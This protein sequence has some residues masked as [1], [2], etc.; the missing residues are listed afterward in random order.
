MKK[1]ITIEFI[2]FLLEEY[3]KQK[4]EIKILKERIEETKDTAIHYSK[5]NI[6]IH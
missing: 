4:E 3:N 1:E 2:E 5:N 6:K